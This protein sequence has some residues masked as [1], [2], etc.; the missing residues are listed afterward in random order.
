MGVLWTKVDSIDFDG[1]WTHSPWGSSGTCSVAGEG[2]SAVIHRTDC[3]DVELKNPPVGTTIY[4][5]GTT[6]IVQ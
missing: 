5:N 1:A 4:V 2:A 6:A 3:P